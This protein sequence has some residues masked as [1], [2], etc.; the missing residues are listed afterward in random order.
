MLGIDNYKPDLMG[1]LSRWPPVEIHTV[2]PFLSWRNLEMGLAYGM[3]H[4]METRPRSFD[5]E[6]LERVLAD[7]KLVGGG[8]TISTEQ[9]DEILARV[10]S[11]PQARFAIRFKTEIGPDDEDLSYPG[12]L[13]DLGHVGNYEDF[14]D[15]EVVADDY[16]RV[17]L[18]VDAAVVRRLRGG[19][20]LNPSDHGSYVPIGLSL[21]YPIEST[22]AFI[23]NA[24]PAGEHYLDAEDIT[25]PEQAIR[26]RKSF[27]LRSSETGRVFLVEDAIEQHPI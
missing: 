5:V 14:F 2:S 24:Q 15:L 20:V 16:E 18:P 25:T 1:I 17:G 21:G 12:T 13:L 10:Q 4:E 19:S 11:D 8:D 3:S 23:L 27:R 26:G 9:A 7:R 22:F 6:V